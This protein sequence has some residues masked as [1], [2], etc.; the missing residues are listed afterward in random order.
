M[1]L[2]K[3]AIDLIATQESDLDLTQDQQDL[4]KGLWLVSRNLGLVQL[5]GE[6]YEERGF[7]FSYEKW[8]ATIKIFKGEKM[9]YF[10]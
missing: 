5:F 3:F 8:G 7:K 2:E 9:M 6:I 10:D 4:T 1:G